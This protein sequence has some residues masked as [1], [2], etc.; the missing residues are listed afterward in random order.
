MIWILCGLNLLW[1]VNLIYIEKWFFNQE[2]LW[3]HPKV[4][5][6]DEGRLIPDFKTWR[7]FKMFVAL[8]MGMAVCL[9]VLVCFFI[10]GK[11]K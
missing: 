11:A 5:R 8:N 4:I 7:R 3:Y 1:F 10:F 2:S 9:I 6:D